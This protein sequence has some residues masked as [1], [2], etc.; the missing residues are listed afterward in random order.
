MYEK[1]LKLSGESRGRSS[2]HRFRLLTGK[3]S[4]I[5]ERKWKSLVNDSNSWE[6]IGSIRRCFF[7]QGWNEAR[8]TSVKCKSVVFCEKEKKLF[9]KK[10]EN[11]EVDNS[12][13]W[14]VNGHEYAGTIKKIPLTALR[15][16]GGSIWWILLTRRLFLGCLRCFHHD[17]TH[18]HP[19]NRSLLNA[20][21]KYSQLE[22]D[23]PKTSFVASP[24]RVEGGLKTVCGSD[25]C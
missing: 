20:T 8:S 5:A 7:D 6:I 24:E 16:Q 4:V 22:T 14:S 9:F 17:C 19:Q 11:G 2:S 23:N 10:Q 3:K 13:G 18:K 12:A 1:K 21:V 25:S 15:K